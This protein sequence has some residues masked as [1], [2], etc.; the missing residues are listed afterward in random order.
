MI[1][2][3]D[4]KSLEWFTYLDLSRDPVGIDEWISNIDIHTKNKKD[5]HLPDRDISKVFLFRWIYMGSAYAYSKDIRFST[6]STDVDFWQNVIDSYYNKY[7]NVLRLHQDLID[8]AKS[9]HP[10]ISP[11]G[12]MYTYTPYRNKRGDFEWP[13]TKISNHIN[14]GYGSDL[15]AITRGY[16]FKRWKEE[17]LQGK[18]INTI[19]DSIVVDVP[20]HEVI[21]A[22]DLMK[23]AVDK[24][25]QIVYDRFSY[26]IPIKLK[27]EV[28]VGPNQKDTK[29]IK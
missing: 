1:V 20:E 15:V 7:R 27:I 6:V 26:E 11:L 8:K 21:P 3:G 25:P 10:I 22:K 18:L 29:E 2:S 13:K 12:R 4:F 28:S 16:L 23:E 9:G 17:Q 5:N 14:Q 19:H 24:L